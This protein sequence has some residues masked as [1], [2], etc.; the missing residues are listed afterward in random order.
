MADFMSFVNSVVSV[1]Q[2]AAPTFLQMLGQA[3]SGAAS[4][5]G[6]GSQ[7]H[8]PLAEMEGIGGTPPPFPREAASQLQAMQQGLSEIEK[9]RRDDIDDEVA[10]RADAWYAKGGE[11]PDQRAARIEST[12][13]QKEAML[14]QQN[15]RNL[16]FAHDAQQRFAQLSFTDPNYQAKYQAL[17]DELTQQ[18]SQIDASNMAAEL[19]VG[20][21]PELHGM[22]DQKVA[23]YQ[24]LQAQHKSQIES[25][26]EYLQLKQ[27]QDEQTAYMSQLRQSMANQAGFNGGSGQT[28]QTAQLRAYAQQMGFYQ[29]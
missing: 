16:Q 23:G 24:A 25:S 21:P 18:Q 3:N 14:E 11:T 6:G 5:S 27:Y 9:H 17:A 7:S 22:V 19:K 2:Y 28:S 26:P 1:N 20:L 29:G 15:A 8:N 10:A 13:Q 12:N 4:A